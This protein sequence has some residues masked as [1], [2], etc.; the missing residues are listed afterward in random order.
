MFPLDVIRD[1]SNLGAVGDARLERSG[2]YVALGPISSMFDAMTLFTV[3]Q[4]IAFTLWAIGLYIV[5]RILWRKR[6]TSIIRELGYF[7]AAFATLL[8]VYAAAILMPRP[9]ARLVI[10]RSDVI[11]IDFHAH[12][13]HSHD[14]RDGWSAEKVR[15]WHTASGYTV[16]YITDHRTLEG[17]REGIALDSAFAGQG[18]TV[19]LPGIEVFF[20]G[21]HV[22]ILNVGVKYRGVTTADY[23]SVDE[24]A[25]ILMSMIPGA[26]PVL[27]ETIPGNLDQLT[28]AMG[29]GTQGVRAIEIVDGSPR[30]MSQTKRERARIVALAD[31]FNL[32]L[33]AGTD[34]H[35]WGKTA[36]GWTLMRIPGEWRGYSPDSLANMIDQIIRVAGR[37][38]TKV[39][40]RTTADATS[41][42]LAFA[43]PTVVWTVMRTLTSGERVAWV[44]WIWIPWAL[45]FFAR[46]RR[47]ARTT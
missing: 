4:I 13:E 39:V 24:N 28:P 10:P 19:L 22:N 29:P 8:A 5:L 26:E 31:T 37:A 25:L 30:G 46:R 7:A 27:I 16:A 20:R 45:A 12:T 35:G 38:G 18:G 3:G 21:E 33:V 11:S 14:G 42:H 9:M 34:N 32:A 44:L 2:G 23:I 41:L 47:L 43:M 6:G 40:E 36:P 17:V 15:D 1:A